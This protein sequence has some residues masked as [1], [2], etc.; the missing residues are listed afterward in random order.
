MDVQHETGSI[1]SDS[2]NNYVD[3]ILRDK[4]QKFMDIDKMV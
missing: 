1:N 3:P 4:I 2:I